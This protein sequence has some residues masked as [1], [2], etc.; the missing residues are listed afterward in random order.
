MR[1]AICLAAFLVLGGLCQA[2]DP[3]PE[4]G[5]KRDTLLYVRTVPTGAKV[6]LDGKE[7]GTS[8]GVF[9]VEPGVGTVVVELEGHKAGK[10]Q[11][12]IRA[13]GVTRVALELKP[14]AK[15]AKVDRDQD[16]SRDTKLN[17]P[18][19][20]YRDWTEKQF[21]NLLDPAPW[22]YLRSQERTAEEEKMLKRLTSDEAE[23]RIAAINALAALGSRKAVPG[24]LKIAVERIEKDN[25]DRWMAVRALG[26]IG[27][28]SAAPELVHL[29]Y[30]YNMNTRF[31]AQISLVR[32]TG[33]NFGRDVAAWRQWWQKQGKTPPIAEE[34]V[35]WA[36]S[37][38]AIQWSDSKKMDEIDRQ[39]ANSQGGTGAGGKAGSERLRTKQQAK[40]RNR[41]RQ[42]LRTFS[43]QDRGEIESLYQV[44]NQKWQTQE[45]RDSLKKLIE[46][47]K[48]AN[49]TGCA[50]LYL[51][52]MSRGDEQIAYLKQAI[53]NHSDCFY[54]DGVQVGAFARLLLG[55]AYL[56][57]GDADSAKALFDEIRKKYPDAIDHRGNSLLDQ[58]PQAEKEEDDAGISP[59]DKDASA[60][61][62][63][64]Q[65]AK[66]G[67]QLWQERKLDE[68]I[69]KFEAALRM[70]PKNEAA[71]NG[72]GWACFNSG[73]T[74]KAQKAFEQLVAINP[75][76]PAALNGL[77]QLH[78]AQKEYELAEK[79]LLKA[80]PKAPAAWYGLA[81]LYLL[82]GK[83][84]QAE[85]YAQ[86]IV[87]SGQGDESANR[88]LKAAKEKS[89]PEE[90]RVVIEPQPMS[91]EPTTSTEAAPEDK[92]G[93]R[94]PGVDAGNKT[95]V[96][97]NILKN[98]GVEAGGETPEAWEQGAAIDG[99]K[100]SWDKAVGSEGKASL[101]IEKTA[102]RYFPIAQWS[103]TVERTGSSSTLAVSAQVKA[104]KMTK[105]IL[106]VIFL[107]K[108][109]QWISHQWAS[110]IGSKKNGQPPANH[111]WKKY[112]GNVKIPPKTATITIA[113]QVYGPGKVWFDDV[114]ARYG[115]AG[116]PR[117]AEG[118][119]D[120]ATEEAAAVK[121][122]EAWLALV[123]QEKYEA[124][125]DAAAEG[126]RNVV[127]KDSF[128]KSLKGVRSP[129]GAVKSR[130]LSSKQFVT[131]LPGAPDG[132]YVVIQFKTSF[133]N[134]ESAVE[135]ITPMLD[136]DGSWRVSGYYIK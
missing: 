76:H 28:P 106:D 70:A 69:A 79:Y 78:L 66:R 15:N 37:P 126:F 82:Q 14:E 111:D 17:G 19:R 83:F 114:Q 21:A 125:W 25:R 120:K 97:E 123:D 85:K 6:L 90:L 84:E 40:A 45:A 67:W 88:M 96:G 95:P 107:D 20:Q 53:E 103:Q 26:I 130:E 1:T 23:E 92:N 35:A 5:E 30:H 89:L 32:L 59:E 49:R 18:Q 122:A 115:A 129:L 27:D 110:Y 133:A 131:K 24:L 91:S 56:K 72:L 73:K 55:Q 48:K 113:L 93:D 22:M 42:D 3:A 2:A 75:D 109:G 58:L 86:M 98:P 51:G 132:Q 41:M 12:T 46:K 105:A 31:W 124:S 112:A 10:K 74:P 94:S 77:G 39:W 38:E 36:T 4:T 52:Q 64:G 61:P 11:V 136:K 7:L 116:A 63:A 33:E 135:T 101:C 60:T 108:D 104:E 50:I 80:A 118:S 81:R 102:S 121:A 16:A 117:K 128:V 134:K 54:G 8:D 119:A 57:A 43:D 13:D 34:T 68:A 65:L 62:D 127:S 100:Y 47:Y 87:D 29:T 71:L 44:A 99:V 9:H